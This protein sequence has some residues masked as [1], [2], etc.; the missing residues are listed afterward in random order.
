MHET[1]VRKVGAGRKKV[2]DTPTSSPVEKSIRSKTDW[3]ILVNNTMKEQ[4][5]GLKDTLK[6]IKEHN[7]YK[8]K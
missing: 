1:L 8:K 4:A 3:Q 7:L 2:T 5:L 6:Y